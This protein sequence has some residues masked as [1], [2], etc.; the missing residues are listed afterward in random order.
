MWQMHLLKSWHVSFC[1]T[2]KNCHIRKIARVDY[3]SQKMWHR[4]TIEN[5]FHGFQKLKSMT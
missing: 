2:N 1:V 4:R 5:G 3:S